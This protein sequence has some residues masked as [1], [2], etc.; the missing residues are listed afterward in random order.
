MN[1]NESD[2][3]SYIHL[4]IDLIVI[5][6]L[7]GCLMEQNKGL[8]VFK[9]K[10]VK[11]FLQFD[12][13]DGRIYLGFKMEQYVYLQPEKKHTNEEIAGSIRAEFDLLANDYIS[14]FSR[15]L[16]ETWRKQ[17]TVPRMEILEDKPCVVRSIDGGLKVSS[18]K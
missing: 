3:I 1:G 12:K 15:F 17:S 16:R 2:P 8:P 18:I 6:N 4:V 9:S 13:K 10:Y 5:P 14:E 7:Q 11:P